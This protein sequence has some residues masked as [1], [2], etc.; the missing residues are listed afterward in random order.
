MFQSPTTQEQQHDTSTLRNTTP[1]YQTPVQQMTRK[2]TPTP[3]TP[4]HIHHRHYQSHTYITCSPYLPSHTHMYNATSSSHSTH[5]P[6]GK[7][8][9]SRDETKKPLRPCTYLHDTCM[10]D[11]NRFGVFCTT[12]TVYIIAF[13]YWPHSSVF[14]RELALTIVF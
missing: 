11:Y 9:P 6:I 12:H 2:A 3:P 8:S 4:L 1:P 14:A 13:S 10:H 7:R 5:T